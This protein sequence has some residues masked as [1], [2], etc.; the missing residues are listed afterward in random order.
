M[1]KSVRRREAEIR[2]ETKFRYTS[3]FEILRF[4]PGFKNISDNRLLKL[5]ESSWD[6]LPISFKRKFTKLVSEDK[7]EALND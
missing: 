5:F 6:D 4:I 2:W 7:G 1:T 3:N